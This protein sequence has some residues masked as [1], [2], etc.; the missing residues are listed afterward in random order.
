MFWTWT[1]WI[2]ILQHTFKLTRVMYPGQTWKW[3]LNLY[4]PGIPDALR[5]CK[6]YW[7]HFCPICI[8]PGLLKVQRIQKVT[9]G[10]ELSY[11]GNLIKVLAPLGLGHRG[12]NNFS[13]LRKV[14][15]WKFSSTLKLSLSKNKVL[16]FLFISKSNENL[17]TFFHKRIICR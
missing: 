8:E 1:S 5:S 11:R 7:W 9:R 4:F 13:T 14:L 15:L 10:K 2:L 16:F 17:T 12:G 3:F 6:S